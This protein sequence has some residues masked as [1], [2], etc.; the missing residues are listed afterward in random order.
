MQEADQKRAAESTYGI[1]NV[2]VLELSLD[3]NI[4][5]GTENFTQLVGITFSTL[6]GK[7]VRSLLLDD[8]K[9]EW[10]TQQLLEDDSK[11]V[12]V[13]FTL[14]PSSE[15]EEQIFFEDE[16]MEVPLEQPLE[17]DCIG[18]LIRDSQTN[19]PSHTLWVM[20][21]L[22]LFTEIKQEIG[23][24]LTQFLGF[25][26]H[27]LAEHLQKI[28][29]IP[30][31][32]PLPPFETILCRVCDREI[33]NWFFEQ[34]SEYC[35]LT[36][37]AE[38]RVQ[39]AN[40]MLN[41][42]RNLLQILLDTLDST[43]SQ[44]YPHVYYTNMEL[45]TVLPPSLHDFL[46]SSSSQTKKSEKIRHFLYNMLLE[47][48]RFIDC[49]LAIHLP[50]LPSVEDNEQDMP[51]SS[52][53]LLSPASEVLNAK[54][55]SWCLPQVDDPG[56]RKLFDDSNAL[57]QKKLDANARLINIMYYA[58]RL[59]CEVEDQVQTIVEQYVQD[60]DTQPSSLNKDV[61]VPS[62]LDQLESPSPSPSPSFHPLY[63]DTPTSAYIPSA[64]PSN[65]LPVLSRANFESVPPVGEKDSPS[66]IK[67]IRQFS[68]TLGPCNS[69]SST[70]NTGVPITS[71]RKSVSTM[72]A[73]Y[74]V[75]SYTS[76]ASP[77]FRPSFSLERSS[78]SKHADSPNT[79][80]SKQVGISTIAP[81]STSKGHPS[82]QDYEIIK[83]ISRGTFGTVY[84]SKKK[85]VGEIYAI[86]VLRK[87]DMILKNQVAN[88]KAE[89]AILMAQE[90]S[91]FIAKLYYAFQSKDYLYLVMEFMN[92]GD[93]ASLLKSLYAI[94]ESWA[95][96]YIA[97]VVLGLEHLHNLGIIHRDIK[98]E[99]ILMS[100]SG[101]LKLADF[102]L[103]QMGLRTRQFRLQKAKS[104]LSPPSFQSP[105]C[106]PES[107]EPLTNSPLILPTSVGL[108]N[109]S[110]DLPQKKKNESFLFSYQS[111]NEGFGSSSSEFTNRNSE[112]ESDFGYQKGSRNLFDQSVPFFKIADAPRKFVGTPDYLA[113]ETIQGSTQDDMVDWWALGCVFFECLFGYPPF[114]SDTPEKVFNNIVANRINWPDLDLYPCSEEALDLIKS[115]LKLNP[116][117]RLGAKGI[118]E[119]K[120]HP[121]FEGIKWNDL[122]S[123]EAPFVPNLETPLDTV[124]FDDRGA[125]NT[126]RNVTPNDTV[127]EESVHSSGS[128]RRVQSSL[129]RQL[130]SRDR[131]ISG[132]RHR[133][134]SE[135]M[136]EFDEFGSFSYKN[137]SVLDQ[138]NKNAIEKIRSE[139]KS[140]LHI[141]LPAASSAPNSE[142]SS[143]KAPDLQSYSP[144][145][146]SFPSVFSSQ[147]STPR[148]ASGVS[149]EHDFKGKVESTK[150][151]TTDFVKQLH[152]RKHSMTNVSI[153]SSESD[154]FL[155]LDLLQAKNISTDQLTM[156]KS[157]EVH[158]SPLSSPSVNSP[159]IL[160]SLAP[161]KVVI[162][163]DKVVSFSELIKLLKSYR[164]QVTVVD[165][166]DKM[167]RILMSD[168][169]FSLIFLQLDL[170]RIS[171]I[172]ILKIVRSSSCPNRNTPAIALLP[173][174]IDINAAIP[175][176]FDGRLYLP[177]NGYLLRGYI[178]RLCNR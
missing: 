137:L 113:P 72:N 121:F 104:V 68:S 18:I 51:F 125:V 75:G 67:N 136:N 58:E 134:F 166:E 71:R 105:T 123:H 96:I 57:V 26:A 55:L 39:R 91:P 159:T 80:L 64:N 108:H 46:K 126:E 131:S 48:L 14:T 127:D 138:A 20:R 118:Q 69:P 149:A 122:L 146:P 56:L 141:M 11:S 7:C 153:A 65:R 117:D 5:Y 82:I 178:A 21:P 73:I 85:S 32:N 29:E 10:A 54:S 50:S 77:K 38:A 62:S 142:V 36:H 110:S 135:N 164:F 168:E 154:D 163:V 83:P 87:V 111:E 24:Q 161:L 66:S 175:R 17:L 120:R 106:F 155:S 139:L 78:L 33:Q 102:G 173:S 177:I 47:T 129:S 4:L 132:R 42:Q 25:G 160:T 8:E 124:Y 172:S 128:G 41:E 165:D 43:Y 13:S 98:P 97:E 162:C 119:I 101:H 23:Q 88:V 81:N 89:K 170:T 76:D 150:P 49:S 174:R 158:S 6:I 93:C 35:L 145:V 140:K 59:R 130:H 9:F 12:R 40:D 28:K 90:E 61:L 107:N 27:L 171:G 167:L 37:H 74:G 70:A 79:P 92:G 99:N 30:F 15:P 144:G 19:D 147:E 53:R 84:L 169:K 95:K 44:D 176:L 22:K 114:H 109:L 94:P 52:V 151:N 116:E 152:L 148:K 143:A 34:H 31:P 157:D 2:Y 103:S 112:S 60:H 133:R 63:T 86:K 115:F 100:S 156:V 16:E 45:G 1:E 3:G